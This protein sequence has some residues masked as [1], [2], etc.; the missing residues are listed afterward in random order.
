MS[1]YTY[2]IDSARGDEDI[3]VGRAGKVI[4]VTSLNVSKTSGAYSFSLILVRGSVE[5]PLYS[6]NLDE[7]DTLLDDTPYKI[8]Q[9]STLKIAS[10]PG[11]SLTIIGVIE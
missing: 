1:L 9:S 2:N 11:V 6:Y 4:T 8:D 5:S 7:G 3:L 10:T